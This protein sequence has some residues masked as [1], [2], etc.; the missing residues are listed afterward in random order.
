MP[1]NNVV[2]TIKKI[3]PRRESRAFGSMS[4]YPEDLQFSTQNAGEKVYILARSHVITNFGWVFRSVF[5]M[6]LPWIIYYGVGFLNS[7]VI[8]VRI[9]IAFLLPVFGW[10]VLGLVYYGFV[11][12]Y[13]YSNYL[14]WYFNLY[15]ITNERAIYI[16]FEV[17]KGK[18]IS[19][20]PLKNIED[21]SQN[22][23]GF[24]PTI[25]HYGDV[26]IQTSATR[27]NFQFKSVADPTWFR[28]VLSDLAKVVQQ[29]EP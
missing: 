3:L 10:I 21:F 7:E 28:D 17:F 14:N 27:G 29:G 5:G 20:V 8:G 18:V 13:A 9:N 19:E 22:I 2:A 26:T 1:Q 24:F 12:T 23:I 15:L 4:T 16:N 6:L 25:F 11:I